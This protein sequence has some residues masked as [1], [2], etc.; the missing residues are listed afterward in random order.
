MIAK[1]I[2]LTILFVIILA[3]AIVFTVGTRWALGF[4]ATSIWSII[5]FVLIFGL[6]DIAILKRSKKE[7]FLF[8]LI[9]FPVLYLAG[10][11]VL[12]SGVFPVASILTG[13]LTS[14]IIIGVVKW[15]CRT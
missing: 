6:L 9:K 11:A 5:N 8:L 1:I 12:V 10:F 7:L 13:L 4:L 2:K 15:N 14:T 3:T